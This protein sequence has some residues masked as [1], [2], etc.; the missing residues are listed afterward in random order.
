M[1][2][3]IQDHQ[4]KIFDK[5]ALIYKILAVI[6]GIG[7]VLKIL[8]VLGIGLVGTIVSFGLFLPIAGVMAVLAIPIILIL[9][10]IRVFLFWMAGR[11]AQTLPMKADRLQQFAGILLVF[12]IIGFLFSGDSSFNRTMALAEVIFHGFVL[13]A[14]SVTRG[15]GPNSGDDPYRRP[16]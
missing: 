4:E 5:V 9:F 2:T 6:S 3:W 13:Y 12:A 11:S 14:L 1:K 7:M 16:L 15:K 8:S 10:G